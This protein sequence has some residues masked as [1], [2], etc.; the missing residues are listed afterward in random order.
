MKYFWFWMVGLSVLHLALTYFL[1]FGFMWGGSDQL[2]FRILDFP[3]VTVGRKVRILPSEWI[4]PL[5]ILN[6]LLWGS[7]LALFIRAVLKVWHH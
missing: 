1:T 6:S 2:L 4:L 3:F 7:L 5:Q